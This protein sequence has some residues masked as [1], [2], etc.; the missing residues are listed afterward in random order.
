VVGACAEAITVI[1]S[2]PATLALMY[3]M[4]ENSSKRA[5]SGAFRSH[6]NNSLS[7]DR[8]RDLFTQ[9]PLFR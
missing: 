5:E 6:P 2:K 7:N 4:T 9:I 3:F 8:C 1:Q